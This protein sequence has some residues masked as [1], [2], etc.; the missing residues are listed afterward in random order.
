[1]M[2]RAMCIYIRRMMMIQSLDD[3]GEGNRQMMMVTE[4]SDD[5]GEGNL[6]QDDNDAVTR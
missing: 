6:T 4:S 5:D 3:D 2:T 1:M